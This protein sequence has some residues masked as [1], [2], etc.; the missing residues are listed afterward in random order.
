MNGKFSVAA[1]LLRLAKS[2][3]DRRHF[4]LNKFFKFTVWLEQILLPLI[5]LLLLL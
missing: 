5:A 2:E 1:E 3:A 4:L